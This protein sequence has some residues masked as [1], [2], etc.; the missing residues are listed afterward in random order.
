MASVGEG[1]GKAALSRIPLGRKVLV[2]DLC[3]W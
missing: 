3:S 1:F 2:D